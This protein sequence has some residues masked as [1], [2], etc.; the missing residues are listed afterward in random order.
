MNSFRKKMSLAVAL[1]GVAASGNALAGAVIYNTGDATTA[2]VALGVNDE[3]HLNTAPNITANAVAT[4]LAYR[5]ADGSWRDATSPGCLCE[6][7]GVAADSISGYASA[8]FGGATNLTLDSFSSSSS[9]ATS[10]VHLTSLPGLKVEHAYKPSSDSALFEAVVT[11]ENTTG[12]DINDLRYRR[13]MDWDIPPDEFN[14]YVTI[15]GVAT[16]TLLEYSSDNGFAVPDPLAGPA[17]DLAGCGET[18][19]F[20]DC[21]PA[22][23]GA[24]FNFNFGALANGESYTF[25]IFYGATGSESSAIAAL[26]AVGAELYSLGQYSGDP[27]GG[28][29]ATYIFGFKG[30]GG[31]PIDSVP[32]PGVLG[33]MGLGMM[34]MVA[35]RRRRRRA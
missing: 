22:D 23:H 13:A 35:V 9:T 18:T 20:V 24:L 14:E 32:E 7:W 19:D 34:G 29:P 1:L 21:G 27:T 25:S 10:M 33:L 17:G 16:T 4:G 11:I 3:G 12:S 26:T 8:D 28:T 31:K 30:V 5:F 15:Q 2:T 6:G